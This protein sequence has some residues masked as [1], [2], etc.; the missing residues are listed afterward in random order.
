M[1]IRLMLYISTEL[2]SKI[3]S[4]REQLNPPVKQV[5]G[6]CIRCVPMFDYM[7]TI[8]TRVRITCCTTQTLFLWKLICAYV[9]CT[10]FAMEVNQCRMVYC[11]LNKS[12]LQKVPLFPQGGC[13][14][15]F[16]YLSPFLELNINTSLEK[17]HNSLRE[18]VGDWSII[19]FLF[20]LV[21]P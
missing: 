21:L 9:V 17:C 12:S 2:G 20:H 13:M 10:A 18:D 16:Y 5:S 4:T 14:W 15:L 7:Y 3:H 8:A 19:S 6:C 11:T 1:Y